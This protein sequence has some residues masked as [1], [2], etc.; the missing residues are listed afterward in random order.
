MESSEEWGDELVEE[1]DEPNWKQD[2]AHALLLKVNRLSLAVVLAVVVMY[3]FLTYQGII[4]TVT[5]GADA[6]GAAR[7]TLSSGVVCGGASDSNDRWLAPAHRP[8]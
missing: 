1:R 6:K 4:P 8:R 2:F 5:R 7:L 3:G